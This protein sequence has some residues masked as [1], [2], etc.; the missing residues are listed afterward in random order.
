MAAPGGKRPCPQYSLTG[1]IM[2]SSLF[3]RNSSAFELA[4]QPGISHR[5]GIL[6]VYSEP[7]VLD[8]LECRTTPMGHRMHQNAHF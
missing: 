7:G 4:S 2:F 8:M 6:V 5:A 1:K 3:W